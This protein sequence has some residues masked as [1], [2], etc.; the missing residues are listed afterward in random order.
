MLLVVL[1][2]FTFYTRS[3]P[4]TILGNLI[5]ITYV[6]C[7]PLFFAVNG[8]LVLPRPLNMKKHIKRLLTII[9]V[10]E[11]WKVFAGFFFV[12]LDG[13]YALTVKNW[14]VFLLGGNLGNYPTGYFWF[15]NALIAVYISL[16]V[17][18][19]VFDS[20]NH[21]SLYWLVGALT[22]FTV[23]LNS[24]V[25][26]LQMLSTLTS[27]DL[28]HLLDSMQEFNLWGQYG[29]VLLYFVAG[30]ILSRESYQPE[31]K[32]L[33]RLSTP[34]SLAIVAICYALT[35]GIQRYQHVLNATNF[36][37]NYGYFLLPTL[38]AALLILRMLIPM[39]TS[40]RIRRVITF[41]GANTFGVYMLHLFALIFVNKLQYRGYLLTSGMHEPYNSIFSVLTIITIYLICTVFSWTGSKIPWVSK[42]FTLH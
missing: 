21:T 33:N 8:A 27:H 10:V 39:H 26:I 31:S 23:I 38:I 36:T 9:I 19:T 14:I 40:N 42:M 28:S 15:M 37:V 18:K 12:F 25:V 41:L 11:I 22:A 24:L 2:H 7:V 34:L 20:Q 16:P 1:I 4:N 5:S 35:F 17:I 13:S 32:K 29:Y 6:I 30:G 3:Y